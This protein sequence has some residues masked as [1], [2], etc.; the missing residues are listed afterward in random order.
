VKRQDEGRRRGGQQRGD[1]NATAGTGPLSALRARG[2]RAKKA[3]GQNFLTDPSICAR[4]ADAAG[5]AGGTVVEIGPGAGAITVP[6][7][8]RAARVVA[9][10]RDRDLVAL[11]SEELAPQIA[12]GELTIIEGD[13]TA[14][15]WLEPLRGGPRPHAIA[16]NLPY[17]LTGRFL[18]LA[19]R[20]ADEVDAIVFMVQLEVADR[21]LAAPG[22][23]AYGALTVFVRAAFDVTRVM[24]VRA[25][26]FH[27]RPEVDSCVVRLTP[28]RPRR[29]VEDEA[30]RAVVRA[31][32]GTRR[33]TLR[34]AW[35]GV[36]GLSDEDVASAA[37]AAGIEFGARGETLDVDAF[38]RFAR[39]VAIRS[40]ARSP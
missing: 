5:A 17:L 21:L 38:A 37:T 15:D 39:E 2:L 28:R 26:A 6:L 29:A 3:L 20:V 18:E 12:S 7:L 23:S 1:E 30:F 40:A 36:L 24:V 16:G 33:K 27:P 34:N 10:E 19:T 9:I 35:R 32:F 14:I 22:T 4:I 31:A 25:G 13:A 8:E 11:L